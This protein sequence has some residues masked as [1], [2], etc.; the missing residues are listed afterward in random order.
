MKDKIESALALFS[1]K[2]KKIESTYTSLYRDF[3]N[4]QKRWKHSYLALQNIITHMS[5][6]VMFIALSGVITLYNPSIEKILELKYEEIKGRLF[7]DIFSDQFFGFSLRDLF[8]RP[9][10][11]IRIRALLHQN[12]QKKE[13]EVT[14]SNIPEY[15]VMLIIKDLTE[16]KKLEQAA[17]QNERLKDIGQM[18]ACLAHEIRNPLGGIQGFASLLM[19]QLQDRPNAQKMAASILEGS[20]I[21]NTLVTSILAYAKPLTLTFKLHDLCELIEKT[22][23]LCHAEFVDKQQCIVDIPTEGLSIFCDGTLLQMT[24]LNLLRNAFQASKNVVKITA[25]GVHHL[26]KIVIENDGPGIQKENLDKVFT[27]FFTTKTDG[28]GLGL[29]EAQKVIL[30]HGGFITVDSKPNEKT[31]FTIQLELEHGKNP[32]C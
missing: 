14:A 10:Q 9:S 21:L 30:A 32:N 13:L 12:Q 4:F 18:A 27:P 15:G 7:S 11:R 5:D 17:L 19:K 29:S 28:T 2:T 8:N 24:L 22:V 16:T 20:K 1:S 25:T 3:K 26:G 23:H 31:T 6:G